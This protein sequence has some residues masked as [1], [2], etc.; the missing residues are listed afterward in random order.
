MNEHS[1]EYYL[2]QIKADTKEHDRSID[3]FLSNLENISSFEEAFQ[4]CI[5]VSPS[6]VIAC[7]TAYCPSK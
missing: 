5:S 1:P 3:S 4:N 6:T 2:S 7:S